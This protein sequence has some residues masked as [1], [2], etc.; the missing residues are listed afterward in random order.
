MRCESCG[1]RDITVVGFEAADH[2]TYRYC[3]YCESGW[4]ESDGEHVAVQSI[5][6]AAAS[7]EPTRRRS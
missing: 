5:L 6:K 7:I 1:D 3:R 2:A 4:W